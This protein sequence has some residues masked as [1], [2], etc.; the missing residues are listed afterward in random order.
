MRHTVNGNKSLG[1]RPTL[2]G[3]FVDQKKLRFVLFKPLRNQSM[4]WMV[5]VHTGCPSG[6]YAAD[7][8]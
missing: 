6:I 4:T 1:G 8:T 2:R 3:A 7:P 5:V